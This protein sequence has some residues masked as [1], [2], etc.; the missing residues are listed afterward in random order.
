MT[1]E[2][3]SEV[4]KKN[5]PGADPRRCGLEL[6]TAVDVAISALREQGGSFQNGNDHNTVKDWPPY[7]DLP[8]EQEERSKGC[9]YCQKFDDPCEVPMIATEED[10]CDRGIYLY[11][12]YLCAN[13]GSFCAAKV[14][15]CPMCGRRLEKV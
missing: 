11:N 12:G 8:R 9:D 15:F 4:L 7:M 14:K 13:G 5:R 3:V 1:R 2:D 10:E 6:C